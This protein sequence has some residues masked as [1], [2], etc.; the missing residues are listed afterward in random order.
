[1]N[2]EN[3]QTKTRSDIESML[4]NADIAMQACRRKP[5]AGVPV[6]LVSP[7]KQPLSR[8]SLQVAALQTLAVQSLAKCRAA[9]RRRRRGTA[10]RRR[11]DIVADMQRN[12]L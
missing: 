2:A 8:R 1:M 12:A 3:A 4:K 5:Q 11:G 10:P 9:P 6:Q 7:R